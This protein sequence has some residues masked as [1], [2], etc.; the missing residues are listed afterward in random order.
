MKK[1]PILN[2]KQVSTEKWHR[3]AAESKRRRDVKHG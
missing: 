3:L 2:I 1:I